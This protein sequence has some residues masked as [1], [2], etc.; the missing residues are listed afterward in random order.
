MGRF[1]SS[2]GPQ[3]SY[4]ESILRAAEICAT[5]KPGD[6]FKDAENRS[7]G[8]VTLD[9]FIIVPG[10]IAWCAVTWV[11]GGYDFSMKKFWENDSFYDFIIEKCCKSFDSLTDEVY[12]DKDIA[13][14]TMNQSIITNE[15]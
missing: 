4:R 7:D 14:W 5:L 8:I 15:Q 10:L 11:K 3:T 6:G 13:L 1:Y 2:N 12:N 9:G